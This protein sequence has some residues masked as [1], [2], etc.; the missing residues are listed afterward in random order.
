[1][2]HNFGFSIP[3][4]HSSSKMPDGGFRLQTPKPTD[5]QPPSEAV[6]TL[7]ST[8]WWLSS[9]NKPAMVHCLT[10]EVW[11]SGEPG[12][13]SSWFTVYRQLLVSHT[14]ALF[15][16]HPG[17]F[18]R[19]PRLNLHKASKLV[20]AL[21]LPLGVCW[22]APRTPHLAVPASRP[23]GRGGA[24]QSLPGS[25]PFFPCAPLKS[26]SQ[27]GCVMPSPRLPPDTPYL[28]TGG[29]GPP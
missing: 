19:L 2:N 20:P 13:S 7:I 17:K 25:F 14:D 9:N 18:E 27:Q 16:I 26:G 24:N 4:D 11:G 22:D 12:C 3:Y 29:R 1:M 6:I 8:G 15:N 5:L 21:S 10:R 23:W 28:P